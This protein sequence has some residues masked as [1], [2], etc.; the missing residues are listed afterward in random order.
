MIQAISLYDPN[1][2][3]QSDADRLFA[4][5]FTLPW[6]RHTFRGVPVPRMYAWMGIA[7]TIYGEKVTPIHWTP[8]ALE[9][10]QRVKEATGLLFDSLNLNLYRNEF[11]HIGWHSDDESEGLW[12]YPIASVSLGAVRQFQVRRIGKKP[13]PAIP[14]G[15]GSLIIMPAG[16][17]AEYKHRLKPSNDPCGPRINLTFRMMIAR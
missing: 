3:L 15:H 9:V 11:D 8:E 2:I 7:P 10:Q 1:L 4:G 16:S 13:E 12:T 5:L 17:Q 6:K 14:L